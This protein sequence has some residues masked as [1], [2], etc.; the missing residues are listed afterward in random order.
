MGKA[1]RTIRGGSAR[2]WSREAG[3]LLSLAAVSRWYAKAIP[4]HRRSLLEA[5][6]R[7][8]IPLCQWDRALEP[9]QVRLGRCDGL[10]VGN[11]YVRERTAYRSCTRRTV[12]RPF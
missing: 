10:V 6:T 1:R 2:A 8:G 4:I 5:S 11:T 3:L 12:V 9:K 7:N